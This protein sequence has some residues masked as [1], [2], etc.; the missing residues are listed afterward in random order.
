[1][2]D[3]EWKARANWWR[4]RARRRV[5]ERR[6]NETPEQ[7]AEREAERA[8]LLEGMSEPIGT[9]NRIGMVVDALTAVFSR[10]PRDR[11]RAQARL[12]R[13]VAAEPPAGLLEPSPPLRVVQIEEEE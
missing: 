3:A 2:K 8:G 4:E 12:A 7:A 1:M 9:D 6:K 5:E 10:D 11:G 13:R